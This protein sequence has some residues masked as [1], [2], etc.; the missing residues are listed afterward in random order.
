VRTGIALH[1]TQNTAASLFSGAGFLVAPPLAALILS[2][3]VVREG[4]AVSARRRIAEALGRVTPAADGVAARIASADTRPGAW[5]LAGGSFAAGLVIQAL[6]IELGIGG[7]GLVTTGR[8]LIVAITLPALA[9]LL[10]GAPRAWHAPAATS[11]A[12]AAGCLLVSLARLGILLHTSA[13]VPLVGVG[14]TL[15]G[16]GLLGLATGQIDARARLAAGAAGL[17]ML[18][19]LTP[20]PYVI[21]SAQGMVDQ[22]LLTSLGAAAALVA[23]GLTLRRPAPPAPMAGRRPQVGL[24]PT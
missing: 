18:A 2:L 10:L 4:S 19:T 7:S 24:S 6:P 11:L 14:Y 12:G 9:W 23:V 20:A 1:A 8:V 16:I 3:V 21:T 15:M 17:L 5:L 22:G 13:L